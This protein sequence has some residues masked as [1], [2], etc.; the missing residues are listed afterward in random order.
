[1][2]A[3]FFSVPV[4]S[5]CLILVRDKSR[6][7]SNYGVKRRILAEKTPYAPPQHGLRARVVIRS[8]ERFSY[9]DPAGIPQKGPTSAAHLKRS[10]CVF[11]SVVDNMAGGMKTLTPLSTAS[12]K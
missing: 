1:V 6:N 4:V 12:S 11:C 5:G 10:P 9:R 8:G 7:V 3:S 2:G